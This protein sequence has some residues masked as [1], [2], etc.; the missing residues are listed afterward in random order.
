MQLEEMMTCWMHW[1]VGVKIEQYTVLGK[2]EDQGNTITVHS[3][4]RVNERRH[5]GNGGNAFF[6]IKY[7]TELTPQFRMMEDISEAIEQNIEHRT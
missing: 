6:S 4:A 1:L 2:G 5:T 3:G 7:G